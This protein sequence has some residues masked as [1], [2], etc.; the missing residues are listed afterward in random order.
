[1]KNW[2]PTPR[3]PDS[4]LP[5]SALCPAT[6]MTLSPPG[7]RC[8]SRAPR[9]PAR[10][11]VPEVAGRTFRARRA[12]LA[13]VTPAALYGHLLPE[14][15]VDSALRTEA[16][17]FRHGRAALQ[18]HVALSA[19]LSWCDKRLAEI[20]LIHLS[21]GSASTGIACAEAEAPDSCR[22]APRLWS[23]LR[24]L[25]RAG[26]EPSMAPTR[27]VG[28]PRDPG[29]PALAHRR[30]DPSG[31]GSRRRLRASRRDHANQAQG[32]VIRLPLRPN[33]RT[34]RYALAPA[35]RS[36]RDICSRLAARSDRPRGRFGCSSAAL[37]LRRFRL[38]IRQA[39]YRLKENS[40][41][42]IH[43]S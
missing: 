2:R 8:S 10:A 41:K 34:R 22:G 21:D 6:S 39:S 24:R 36:N 40:D 18:I 29:W 37:R 1:M 17:S 13:S 5:R 11:R 27:L 12:V 26:P 25:C 23:A 32:V 15:A 43:R 30:F 38:R 19:P 14:G 42:V 28:P 4:L 20:P 9:T 16:A 33:I 31:S 35:R 3:S 7:T